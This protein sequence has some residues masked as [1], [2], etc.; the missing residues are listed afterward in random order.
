[1]L[2]KSLFSFL[3]FV[4]ILV[5]CKETE[6]IPA[7]PVDLIPNQHLLLGNPSNATSDEANANNYLL[8]KL[9]YSLSYSRDRG[10]PNWVSWHVNKD[11][12]GTAPRQDDFRADN[13]LPM[14]WYKPTATSYSGSGFD[15]GHNCPSGDRT[16]SVEDNSATFLMTN[17]IPQAPKN[18]QETWANLEDYTRKL[19][20]NGNEVY[21]IMG[22]YG[23]GGTGSM[24]AKQTIDNGRVTVP[25][26]IWKV[27]VI[28]PEGIDD[29]N[30]INSSTRVIA[31][32]TP[33]INTV[34][35]EWGTYRT[36]VDAIEKETGYDLLTS[37]SNQVQSNLETKVDTGPTQ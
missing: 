16:S 2:N 30:R 29:L 15:R 14:V 25:A 37:L 32:N 24:G 8:Q 3:F 19:V 34:R 22:S 5:G 4:L 7:K 28:L 23:V 26:Q 33:N 31:V 10:T 9:Q 35:P 11:W 27:L 20:A 17:M 12:L 13:T 18:N 6:V 1:M 36:S 21:V